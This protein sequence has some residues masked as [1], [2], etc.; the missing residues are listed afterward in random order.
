MLGN[1]DPVVRLADV[2]WPH[3]RNYPRSCSL[4]HRP[5]FA[6]PA[7]DVTFRLERHTI[8]WPTG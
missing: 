5:T 2:N 7:D 1:L 3:N 6:R 8:R 4:S